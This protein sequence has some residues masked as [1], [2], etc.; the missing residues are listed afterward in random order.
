MSLPLA[1]LSLAVGQ[2]VGPYR[3]LRL[4]G[5]GGMAQV[6]EAVNE[7][8]GKRVALKVLKAD[9]ASH[10]EMLQ[11]FLNEA[12]GASLVSHAGLVNVFEFGEAP[13]GQ[14][15]IAMEYLE[16]ESLDLHIARCGKLSPDETQTLG[17]QL[18][19]ALATAHTRGVI[20]RDL[21]PSNIMLVPDPEMP[22]GH[23]SKIL[24]FGIA[25]LQRSMQEESQMV[26]QAGTIMGTPAYM[27]PEQWDDLGNVDDQA[28]VYS[29]G[30]ILYECLCGEP[31]FSGSYLQLMQAHAQK[32]AS[33]LL[34]RAPETPPTLRQLVH[35]MLAKQRG[36]RPTMREVE[37]CLRSGTTVTSFE[38]SPPEAI[39][40]ETTA[41]EA[42]TSR[43]DERPAPRAVLDDNALREATAETMMSPPA[44]AATADRMAAATAPPANR[45]ADQPASATATAQ[46]ESAVALAQWRSR[47]YVAISILLL[48]CVVAATARVLFAKK[49]PPAASSA[50]VA[51]TRPA[52]PSTP[53]PSVAPPPP[54]ER[55][56]RWSIRTQP[57]GA[58]VVRAEDGALLGTTPW[59][60]Q[61]LGREHTGL[62]LRRA[63]YVERRLDLSPTEDVDL[64][65]TLEPVT[66]GHKRRGPAEKK[67]REDAKPPREYITDRD[68]PLLK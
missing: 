26:T 54:V 8:I 40:D 52:V 12:R 39:A 3:V 14:V 66:A 31:P 63:G 33:P 2:A 56:G 29:L 68:V 44:A 20:H 4:L 30:V 28:D 45:A 62:L 57:P 19:A 10:P 50:P 22:G 67:P 46:K 48:S 43:A 18:A 53:S 34:E 7:K 1:S 21:K 16:G 6:Y 47:L 32:D 23:R 17:R 41:T 37:L 58:E 42:R 25:K 36:E 35:G 55:R 27:A 5:E 38:R 51:A 9:L 24:D 59:T 61:G 64:A 15:Y 65:L 49:P 11:R 13:S 60:Q